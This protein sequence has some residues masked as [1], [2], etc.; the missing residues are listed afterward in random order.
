VYLLKAGRAGS[1]LKVCLSDLRD[2][3]LSPRS[4][5]ELEAQSSSGHAHFLEDLEGLYPSAAFIADPEVKSP[6]AFE[7]P[8]IDNIVFLILLHEYDQNEM[9]QIEIWVLKMLDH[10]VS[11]I[12]LHVGRVKKCRA[13]DFIRGRHIIP[14]YD[15]VQGLH[16]D[17]TCPPSY[18]GTETADSLSGSID[19]DAVIISVLSGAKEVRTSVELLRDLLC[20]I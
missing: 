12:D 11:E 9:D 14:D 19:S 4:H 18:S 20:H 17:V 15:Y 10:L 16:R 13:R 6:Q 5:A 2:R 1:S 3:L 7:P 8:V